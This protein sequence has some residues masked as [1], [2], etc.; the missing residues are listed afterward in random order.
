MSQLKGNT[1]AERAE[2]P[3]YDVKKAKHERNECLISR[4]VSLFHSNQIHYGTQKEKNERR[5]GRPTNPNFNQLPTQNKIKENLEK[6]IE[7]ES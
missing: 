6:K 1:T 5:Q 3:V 2:N 4:M 7:E